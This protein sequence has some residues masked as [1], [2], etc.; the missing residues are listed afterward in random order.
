MKTAAI[1]VN[2]PLHYGGYHFY[3]HDYDVKDERFSVL[4]VT[5]DTGLYLV[6][7]GFLLLCIGTI[8]HFW[9]KHLQAFPKKI[10][11]LNT[12]VTNGN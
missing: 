12:T 6:Y 4:H 11:N 7:F 8:W 9:L 3:Q 10:N 1:E 2:Y 5:S